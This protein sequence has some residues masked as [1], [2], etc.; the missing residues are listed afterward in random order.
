MKHPEEIIF[1]E[2]NLI[3]LDKGQIA[4]LIDKAKENKRRRCRICTHP[5]ELDPVHEMFIAHEAGTYIVPHKHIDKPESF[6]LIQGEITVVV[7]S[8]DG[9]VVN[10][11][12]MGDYNSGKPFYYRIM[13]EVYHTL[14]IHSEFAI[15]HE[16]TSGPFNR[17][18]T[19]WASWAPKETETEKITKFMEW[20]SNEQ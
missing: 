8:D 7:F 12:D 6:H 20:L 16:T 18:Q 17:E 14:L 3:Q 5:T 9:E 15:F 1:A 13:P 10:R 19:S 2:G 11:I 4:D